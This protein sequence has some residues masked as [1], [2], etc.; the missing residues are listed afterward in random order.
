MFGQDYL[1]DC[2]SSILAQQVLDQ[3][4]AWQAQQQA[5]QQHQSYLLSQNMFGI[6]TV[7]PEMLAQLAMAQQN[8]Y[9][10]EENKSDPDYEE[11]LRKLDEEYPGLRNFGGNP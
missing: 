1:G 8:A 7:H 2:F 9:S 4:K 5:A 10:R 3:R 6:R 11:A